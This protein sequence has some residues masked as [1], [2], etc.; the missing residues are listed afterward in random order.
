[1]HGS[2]RVGNDLCVMCHNPNTTDESKRPAPNM[3]PVTV[4]F[5]DMIHLIHTGEELVDLGAGYTVYGYGGTPHDFTHVRFPGD[6][7]ECTICHANGTYDVPTP[8]EALS[9]YVTEAGAP[10]SEVQPQGAA[11]TTCHADFLTAL[12]VTLNTDAGTGDESCA[13]CHGSGKDFDVDTVHDLG[14]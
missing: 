5:K 7:R 9:T 4:N 12:H 2:L 1:M 6:R 3:P 13:V 14:P 8:P 11:C 10:I